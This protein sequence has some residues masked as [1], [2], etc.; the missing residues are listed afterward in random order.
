MMVIKHGADGDEA[1]K[2]HE[3]G[4]VVATVGYAAAIVLKDKIE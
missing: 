2:M 3:V 1:E 4:V